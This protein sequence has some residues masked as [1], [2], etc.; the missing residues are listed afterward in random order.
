MAP[1]LTT[2]AT[3]DPQPGDKVLV[4][5]TITEVLKAPRPPG[6]R[7]DVDGFGGALTG[8]MQA[9]EMGHVP[10]PEALTAIAAEICP[11]PDKARREPWLQG[12]EAGYR[13]L[14]GHGAT[15]G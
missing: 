11:F 7:I 8:I 5:A 12:F 4:W 6:L 9:E 14:A 10:S 3:P 13:L 1:A 2:A 15:G